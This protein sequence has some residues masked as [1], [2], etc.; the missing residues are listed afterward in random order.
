MTAIIAGSA[1][2]VGVAVLLALGVFYWRRRDKVRTC[3]LR[4]ALSVVLYVD[5]HSADDRVAKLHESRVLGFW[6]FYIF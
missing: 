6:G 1:A 2:G 4:G 3:R 5:Q